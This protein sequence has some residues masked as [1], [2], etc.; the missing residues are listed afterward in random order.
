MDRNSDDIITIKRSE[1]RNMMTVFA[2]EL[3]KELGL[4]SKLIDADWI[5]KNQASRINPK[6]FGRA[7]LEKAISMGYVRKKP[8]QQENRYSKI[9][10]NKKDV[11]SCIKNQTI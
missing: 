5:S 10:V 7:K 6:S 4:K 9:L 2:Q 1:L 11:E 8:G 3:V